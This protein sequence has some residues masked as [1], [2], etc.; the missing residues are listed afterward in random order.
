SLGSGQR[1]SCS[2]PDAFSGRGSVCADSAEPCES[3]SRLPAGR[4]PPR[5]CRW[6]AGG[7]SRYPPGGILQ[8]A[9]RSGATSAWGCFR[10]YFKSH[11]AERIGL[12][13]GGRS[14]GTTTTGKG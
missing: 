8:G 14:Q 2:L 6:T 10:E 13:G 4:R 11:A 1:S 5:R 7:L 9:A 12:V 3:R